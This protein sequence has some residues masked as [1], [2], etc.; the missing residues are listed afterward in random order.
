MDVGPSTGLTVLEF[1]VPSR[2]DKTS[3]PISWMNEPA[4]C[5][6]TGVS[7]FDDWVLSF[8]WIPWPNEKYC[9]LAIHHPPT[10]YEPNVLDNFHYSETTEIIFR[11][12]SS[13]KDVVPSYLHDLEID[14]YTIGRAL[15]SPLFT[16]EREDPASRIQAYDA[17][18]ESLL[19]SE[20]LSVDHIRTG[21][22]LFSM[23]LD[24]KFQTSENIH[25]ATQK[26][27][28]RGFFWNDKESRFSLTVKQRFKNT[29]SRPI[30]IGEVPSRRK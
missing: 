20:S 26:M 17:P 14:D 28:K 3:F 1:L 19:S 24:H 21:R 13:D 29:S 30:L 27:S 22:P 7:V 4:G 11:D 5:S 18:D 6:P 16:Q 25:V 12:A 15:S 10:S 2:P 8:G 9:T 23:N